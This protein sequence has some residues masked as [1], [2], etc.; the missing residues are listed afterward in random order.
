MANQIEEMMQ[1]V[2]KKT[3]KEEN[4]KR[5]K[6]QKGI[7]E[8]RGQKWRGRGKEKERR[9]GQNIFKNHSVTVTIRNRK[10]KKTL[11]GNEICWKMEWTFKKE[12]FKPL[13]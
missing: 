4:K 7:D 1:I 6:G 3:K 8:K 10:A 5:K 2:K 11:W 9:R 12:E 13:N